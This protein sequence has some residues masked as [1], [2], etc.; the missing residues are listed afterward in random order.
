MSGQFE[1]RSL[2]LWNALNLIRQASNTLRLGAVNAGTI[3]AAR[4]NLAKAE[5]L[6]LGA[7]RVDAGEAS[8]SSPLIELWVKSGGRWRHVETFDPSSPQ[9]TRSAAPADY[10]CFEARRQGVQMMKADARV[11]AYDIRRTPR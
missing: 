10:A 7:R 6:I 11:D 9:F 1:T 2:L 3:A 4:E 8:G 5:R